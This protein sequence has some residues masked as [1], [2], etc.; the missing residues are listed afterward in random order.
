MPWWM[1]T[2][3]KSFISADQ[4][5]MALEKGAQVPLDQ[6]LNIS[7]WPSLIGTGIST[8]IYT[9]ENC[10]KEIKLNPQFLHPE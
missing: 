1:K 9:Q 2:A 8:G 5:D 4:L 10:G 7:G 6:V 3:A